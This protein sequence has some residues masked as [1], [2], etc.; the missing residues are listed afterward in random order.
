MQPQGKAYTLT[1]SDLGP[2]VTPCVP[3]TSGNRQQLW[4]LRW[5]LYRSAGL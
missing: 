2:L 1:Q 4:V 5:C 3:C